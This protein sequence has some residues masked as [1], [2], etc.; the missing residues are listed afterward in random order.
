MLLFIFILGSEETRKQG[1]THEMNHSRL[2]SF[3]HSTTL[4]PEDEVVIKVN[5]TEVFLRSKA[6]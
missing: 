6:S 2:T 5:G 4:L 1:I 3:R